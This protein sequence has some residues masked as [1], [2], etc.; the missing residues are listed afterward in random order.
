MWLKQF[1]ILNFFIISITAIGPKKIRWEVEED[2]EINLV[3]PFADPIDGIEYRLPNNTKP[4]HYEIFLSTDIHSNF[5]GFN[6]QVTIRFRAMENT[7]NVTVHFRQLII[8]N[9]DL[10]DANG[11]LIQSNLIT[12]QDPYREF[13]TI[14]PQNSLVKDEIYHMRIDYQGILRNDDAGFYYGS[15]VDENG[16]RR[17]HATTQFES[18]DARHAFPW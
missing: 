18:T 16:V 4:I 15:Y 11:N 8:F 17:Y 14:L 2:E 7:T 13:L 12:T 1:L 6:G 3:K 9:V 10:L 5:F